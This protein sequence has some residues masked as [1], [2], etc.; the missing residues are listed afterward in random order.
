VFLTFRP[1]SEQTV[2]IP[3]DGTGPVPREHH[4]VVESRRVLLVDD[5]VDYAEGLALLLEASGYRVKVMH[6][7]PDALRCAVD[8]RPDVVLL[9]I[10]LPEMDGYEIARRLRQEPT[11]QG[12]GYRPDCCE[13]ML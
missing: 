12:L 6:N 8:F 5:N 11:L 4:T 3:P 2:P 1:E 13:N 9:D 10:G 7:G